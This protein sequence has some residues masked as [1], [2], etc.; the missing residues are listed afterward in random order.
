[1]DELLGQVFTALVMDENETHYFVQKN[2]VT[3]R[4]SKEKELAIGEMVEGFGYVNQKKEA[5]FTL[6]IPQV[7]VGHFAFG[8]VTDVRRD[9][10]AFVDIGL[11]DKDMVVSLDEMPT[12]KELWPKKGDRLM[13]SI[14]VD[15]KD[16][17]WG[18]LADETLFHS[19]SRKGSAEMQNEN[20]KGTI[21]RL[22]VAGSFLITEDLYLGF[23]HPSERYVEP[24]LGE[25]VEARV[26]GV[27]PDGVLNMSLK[28]RSHEMINDDAAMILTM[29]ERNSEHKLPY[30]DKSS[31]EE[32]KQ[33]FGI[34]KGQFK[35]AIGHLLKEKRIV[36]ENGS[37]RLKTN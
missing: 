20:K 36:Q 11:P 4:L 24:R 22:K 34:S 33:F 17:M 1:M 5:V 37:I 12:M 28:P 10:G 15:E 21:Y 16:R 35:R 23:V 2:G 7:R 25:V 26:I 19:L 18:T 9:L 6:E 27:R 30:W 13:I 3:F 14:R 32:I 8:E 29:L 31:P